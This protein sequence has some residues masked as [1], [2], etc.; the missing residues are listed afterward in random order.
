MATSSASLQRSP[1]RINHLVSNLVPADFEIEDNGMR[2]VL[3]SFDAG[4][5]PLTVTVILDRS[6]SMSLGPGGVRAAAER[7]VTGLAPGDQARICAFA[8]F[9][10]CSA[11]Y[12]TDHDELAR[13]ARRSKTGVG[14]RLFDAMASGIEAMAVVPE[15]RRRVLL[16]FSDGEDHG[17]RTTVASGDRARTRTRRHGVRNRSSDPILRWR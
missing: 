8:N 7:F 14:S 6:D 3:T 13:D 1:I 2:Q 9:V 17:S 15:D 10:A 4:V 16:V 11:G 5:R 12:T